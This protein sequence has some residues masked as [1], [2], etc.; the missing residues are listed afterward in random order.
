M[1]LNQIIFSYKF[2]MYRRYY[3]SFAQIFLLCFFRCGSLVQS[4]STAYER[5]PIRLCWS[6]LKASEFGSCLIWFEGIF[7]ML[8]IV[9]CA[10]FY[11]FSAFLIH[12][13]CG[14]FQL[15]FHSH[16]L[17]VWRRIY[18]TFLL[19]YGVVL[20][21]VL[22]IYIRVCRHIFVFFR[23]YYLLIRLLCGCCSCK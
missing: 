23:K 19:S 7:I 22:L 14:W 9:L 6:A 8:F 15:C 2:D 4:A 16:I 17:L 21:M 20:W 13:L 18:Q 1:L 11:L 12:F 3:N 5:E 10:C